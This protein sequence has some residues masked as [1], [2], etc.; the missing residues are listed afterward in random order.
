MFQIRAIKEPMTPASIL[1]KKK[2]DSETDSRGST[3][4]TVGTPVTVSAVS[5]KVDNS[6]GSSPQKKVDSPSE[7]VTEFNLDLPKQERRSEI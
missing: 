1:Y 5:I 4:C 7:T 6:W 3:N 2:L